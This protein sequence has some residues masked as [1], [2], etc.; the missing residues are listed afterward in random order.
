MSNFLLVSRNLNAANVVRLY[1]NQT[2][3]GSNQGNDIYPLS[4]PF[5]SAANWTQDTVH[6]NYLVFNTVNGNQC[7][8]A[9]A[10]N[11]NCGL[12]YVPG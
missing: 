12:N 2:V 11:G 8:A 5:G 9:N 6:G 10:L 1:V 3:L 4:A 7:P